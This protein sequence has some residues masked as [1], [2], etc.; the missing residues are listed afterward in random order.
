MGHETIFRSFAGAADELIPILQKVQAKYGYLPK[1][2]MAAV[3]R[4]TGVP[5]SRIFGVATFY[6]QFWFKPKGKKHV[7]VCRGTACHV[8]GAPGILDAIQEALGLEVG[9][10][11]EDL[12][13]SLETV[14]CI[15]CCALSPCVMVNDEVHAK[16]TPK[17]VKKLFARGKKK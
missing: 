11:T 8:R 13:Y 4:F 1:D 10:T 14:A 15:G 16:L 9:D 5:E 7:M 12:E 2:A 3:A 6:K 17:S